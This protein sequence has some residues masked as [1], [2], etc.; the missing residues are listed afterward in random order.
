MARP[1]KPIDP[2]KVS[3]LARIGCTQEEIAAELECSV[4]T[5]KRRFADTLKEG[6]LRFKV[7]VRRQ[8]MRL[9]TAGNATMGVWLG[10]QVLGQR[11]QLRIG[12][13]EDAPLRVN[14]LREVPTK[15]LESLA[16]KLAAL[17]PKREDEE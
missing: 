2:D 9:L 12:S 1:Q 4:D 15:D 3:L 11:D 16:A 14:A 8:Q 17:I 6:A 5:L 10:K 7:S 13:E